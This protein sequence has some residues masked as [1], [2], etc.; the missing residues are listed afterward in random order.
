MFAIEAVEEIQ[1]V[2]APELMK[3]ATVGGDLFETLLALLKESMTLWTHLF[4]LMFYQD[5]SPT[6]TMFLLLYLWI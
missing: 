2:L 5:L 1:I 4:L 3:D 6:L